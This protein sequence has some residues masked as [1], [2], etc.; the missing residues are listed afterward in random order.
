MDGSTLSGIFARLKESRPLVHHITNYVTVNDCANITMFIGA[1]P[2]M[3]EA[4]EEVSDMVSMA[5]ALVL[6]I[7]TLR[8]EQVES[9]IIAGRR[10]NELKVPIIL[11]PVGA[12]ATRY[13]TET[14]QN[15]LRE[16]RVSIIKGN[17]GEIGTLV[18]AGGSVRG[19]DSAGISG[20]PIEACRT[21][22]RGTGSTVVMSGATDIVS[23]GAVTLLVENGH[24]LMGRISGT[25]CMAASLLG[26]F[27]ASS[28]DHVLSSVA[29]LAAFGIAGERAAVK[30]T[31]PYTFKLHLMNEV[32]ALTP[33][34]LEEEVRV[35]C[36]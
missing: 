12:G 7:G 32:A 10:A 18:G 25:G 33:G 3:A 15:L 14:A 29:A 19:V 24:Q 20:D 27:A 1:A 8:K 26:A 22:A 4:P 34:D 13:R 9:M 23:D 5:G 16:L 11:D 36:P 21:L 30:S 35:R 2:V 6:N 17:A 31:G 28:D